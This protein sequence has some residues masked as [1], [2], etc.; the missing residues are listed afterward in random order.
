[1]KRYETCL[2]ASIGLL[3]CMLGPALAD[4][5]A[6]EPPTRSL[7][8]SIVSPPTQVDQDTECNCTSIGS[9]PRSDR[10]SERE[11]SGLNLLGIQYARG[12]GVKRNPR[13]AMK[14]FVRAAIRG[15]TPA[16]ANLGT[17][18]E[19]GSFGA[20]DLQRAYAWLRAALSFGVPEQDHDATVMK[21]GMIA[22][23]PD[24]SAITRS[25]SM[26]EALAR[27]IVDACNC[28]PGRETELALKAAL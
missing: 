22:A 8:R 19:I 23:R 3:I 4:S 6:P 21:L 25:E 1:M 13:M 5:F 20:P 12:R 11:L 2:W 28:S 18:F 27:Q 7:S 16:M 17:L 10:I 24:A 26:A 9:A 14:I 15:Y